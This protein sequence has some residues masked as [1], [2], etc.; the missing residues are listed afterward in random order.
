MTKRLFDIICSGLGLICLAPVFL[1]IIL[2]IKKDST[3]PIFFRQIRVGR[4]GKTFRIHKFR[5]MYVNTEHQGRLTIGKD[6]RITPSGHFIRQ[7]KLDELAQLIDV[8]IG[9]M[10]LVGPRPEVPEFMSLYSEEEQKI[11]L[12][13]RPGIT[14]KASIE[15]ID[16]NSILATYSDPTQAYID[17][18][19]PIKAKYYIEYVN[20]QSITNDI[21]II[22]L[23]IKKIIRH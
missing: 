3:G 6:P 16:E 22:F 1:Y 23:T 4:H 18:I 12:S 5:S 15:M 7:Y 11:I 17:V 20:N 2:W 14:D 8:F 10:S 19:M 9:T 21:H 13:V